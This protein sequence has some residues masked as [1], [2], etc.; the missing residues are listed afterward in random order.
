MLVYTEAFAI[1]SAIGYTIVGLIAWVICFH[2]KDKDIKI[3]KH[4]LNMLTGLILLLELLKQIQNIIPDVDYGSLW[5]VKG[6]GN[7]FSLYALPFHLCSFFIFWPLAAFFTKG[8]VK[9][10]FENLTAVWAALIFFSVFFY[11]DVIYGGSLRS[12]YDG[13]PLEHTTL[14]HLLVCLY[15]LIMIGLKPFTLS[16]KKVWYAPVGITI[17][18]AVAGLATLI[19]SAFTAPENMPNYCSIYEP[20]SFGFTVEIFEKFGYGLYLP[21]LLLI[22]CAAGTVFYLVTFSLYKLIELINRR[23]GMY[24][25]FGIT[26]ILIVP[27]ALILRETMHDNW[28][29]M[30]FLPLLLVL[31]LVPSAITICILKIRKANVK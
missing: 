23:K 8:K 21:V 16:L 19:F 24:I 2:L 14:F 25:G 31:I 1:T 13:N 22:G 5:F 9:D 26:I 12:L 15:F 11:S 18:G 29:D 17:Y 30:L 10:F 20:H 28:N 27:L 4:V 3:K 6:S 7:E